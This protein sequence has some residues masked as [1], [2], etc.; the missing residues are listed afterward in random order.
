MHESSFHGT[1]MSFKKWLF[2]FMTTLSNSA[3]I[4]ASFPPGVNHENIPTVVNINRAPLK[5]IAP[6]VQQSIKAG[7]YPGAVIIA[8]HD[9]H[10]IYQGVFGN[11]RTEPT[12]TPMSLNT[13]FDIASL[14]KVV[15]TAPAIMQLVEKNHLQLDDTVATYWP[16]FAKHDKNT[17]TIRQLLTHT[18]GLQANIPVKPNT[19]KEA[20]L[21]QIADIHL[22]AKPNT[23]FIYSD[24][25]FIVLAHL[26]EIISKET[27][28]H[29][30][31]T[32]IFQ[33]LD[34]QDTYFN[35]PLNLRERIPPTHTI[36]NELR[37]G[38]VNDYSAYGMGGFTGSAGIFSTATDLA[39]VA[40][41]MLDH[42]RL[43][44]STH[45]LLH[46]A[47]IA[48]MTTPQTP[49]N[50][51]DVRG[52]GWD[53]HSRYAARGTLF[54]QQ[55]YGHTGWTG[56]SMWIDPTT[57]TYVIIL[58]SKTYPLPNGKNQIV[59]DRRV[60]ADLVASSIK[61]KGQHDENP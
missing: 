49:P 51:D 8:T 27:F 24:L 55:S 2:L 45:Y 48:T 58:T 33:P 32:H 25:N 43:P 7:Y 17:I 14:T 11:Q 22:E 4:A 3:T 41:C 23:Q 18:S 13:I 36:N 53:I 26:I 12:I 9:G 34:M 56:T 30:I 15:A 38:E 28:D 21:Q 42:G 10:L 6:L 52:L 19:G 61:I 40:Q 37:W 16:E 54:S 29:Y 57:S 1:H 60:I 47:T 5:K 20:V 44:H 46:P 39:H 59:E 35:P 31:K 50:I